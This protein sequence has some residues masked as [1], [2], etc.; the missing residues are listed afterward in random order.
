MKGEPLC[1][2]LIMVS[3]VRVLNLRHVRS[4]CVTLGRIPGL[5]VADFEFAIDEFLEAGLGG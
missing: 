2:L 5:A 1:S 3:G 4:G